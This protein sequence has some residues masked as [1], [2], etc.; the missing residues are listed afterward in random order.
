MKS[1]L[2]SK[3]KTIIPGI[4]LFSLIP[5]AG[6]SMKV[7]FFLGTS[8]LIR[9]GKSIELKVG[10]IVANGDIIQ[11]AKNGIVELMYDDTSKITIKGNT[12]VQ[13][14]SK[15]VKDSGDVAVISGEVSGKFVKLKKGEHKIGTPSTVCAIRGTEF[16]MGVSKGG[17]S[18]VE[19][20][21][22]KLDVRNSKGRIELNEG[23]TA[24]AELAGEPVSGENEGNLE[25]WQNAKDQ[26]LE[27]N[28]ES[29]A[30]RYESHINNF[31]EESDLSAKELEALSESTK[32]A[33]T[34]EDLEISGNKI[35]NSENKIEDNML[36]NETSRG[37]IENLMNDYGSKNAAIKDKFKSI[38]DRCNKV[39][40]QQLKNYQAIQ[41]VKEDYKKAYDNI[42]KKYK[43][44]KTKIFK[45]LEDYKKT[46]PVKMEEPK[47]GPEQE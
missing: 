9:N 41:K 22:G 8:T 19:L 14:G 35:E 47:E 2:N 30:D 23:F 28:I 34:R 12:E 21:E 3:M 44:D 18:K 42:M 38:S 33:V 15:N 27:T 7:S 24:E 29:Q 46:A 32:K 26:S 13:I 40:E 1:K 16:T 25:E 6:Y 20:K 11:T 36:M 17:D 10:D 45:N 4:L 5:I 31:G 43:D 39:E 37:S